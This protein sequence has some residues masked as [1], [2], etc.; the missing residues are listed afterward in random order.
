[1]VNFA[2]IIKEKT[3]VELS[4]SQIN[5][6][7]SYDVYFFGADLLTRSAKRF[8][9]KVNQEKLREI[10]SLYMISVKAV[11]RSTDDTCKTMYDYCEILNKPDNFDEKDLTSLLV[12]S[13]SKSVNLDEQDFLDSSIVA[14]ESFNVSHA[15]NVK[16]YL[17]ARE[18]VTKYLVNIGLKS[19]KNL[20][21]NKEYN[22][23]VYRILNVSDLLDIVLDFKEDKQRGELGFDAGF[24]DYLKMQKKLISNSIKLISC[25]PFLLKD[26]FV[27]SKKL[28][29]VKY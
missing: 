6:D 21:D 26:F 14:K 12:A 11:D 27:L 19:I 16:D 8:D 20:I 5:F 18:D 28:N 23:F 25:Y 17:N 3:G 1:M 10:L 4:K 13:F 7:E 22:S 9:K 29:K 15:K 2:K 24:I